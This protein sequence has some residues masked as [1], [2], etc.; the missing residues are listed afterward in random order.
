M[1]TTG[2]DSRKQPT[3][4]GI[5]VL[6]VEDEPECLRRFC[7]AV[8][9]EPALTLVGSARTV[10]EACSLVDRVAPDVVLAD[11]GLP[12]GRGIDVIRHSKAGDASRDVIVVTVFG[13][14]GHV[15]DSIRA[16]ATGYLL[17][18][19]LPRDIAGAILQVHDGGSPISPAIARRIL[20]S[21]QVPDADH[22]AA[23]DAGSPGRLSA[24]ETQI[25]RLVEKGLSFKEVGA[26]LAISSHTVTTHVKR[27][28]QKL[29][30]A[31][32]VGGHRV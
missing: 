5:K 32:D 23:D 22:A 17:K 24:R 2:T 13:D 27:I 25:L 12:D 29:E 9:A 30:D 20:Q 4:F 18:D 16:G 14:V 6:V 10:A 28:Y 21:L 11:L 26:A 3:P 15:I 1:F 19:A 8:A 7:G 31:F